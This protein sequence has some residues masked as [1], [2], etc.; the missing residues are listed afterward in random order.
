MELVEEYPDAFG[1]DEDSPLLRPKSVQV[2]KGLLG[3]LNDAQGRVDLALFDRE[4]ALRS[5]DP[6]RPL[7]EFFAGREFVREGGDG[8]VRYLDGACEVEDWGRPEL[9]FEVEAPSTNRSWSVRR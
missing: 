9:T 1:I 7:V 3:Q 8:R 6:G 2:L 4:L 5:E